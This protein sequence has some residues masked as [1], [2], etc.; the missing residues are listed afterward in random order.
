VV[1]KSVKHLWDRINLA[2]ILNC[3]PSDIDSENNKDI[4][5]MKIVL[6]AKNEKDE[7]D[8]NMENNKWH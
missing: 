5:A 6:T 2:L 1:D 4:E 3:L 8:K 7:R